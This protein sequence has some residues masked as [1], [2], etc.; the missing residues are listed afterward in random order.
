MLLFCSGLASV[1]QNVHYLVYKKAK[2]AT[3]E[4]QKIPSKQL[5]SAKVVPDF[6]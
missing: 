1:L 6:H 4:I 2:V 5:S 3:S